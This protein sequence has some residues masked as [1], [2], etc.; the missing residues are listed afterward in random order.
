MSRA[1][2]RSSRALAERRVRTPWVAFPDV[3]SGA[4]DVLRRLEGAI[5]R[6]SGFAP[7]CALGDSAASESSVAFK[8]WKKLMPYDAALLPFRFAID[9]GESVR[10][11][12]ARGRTCGIKSWE[13]AAGTFSARLSRYTC[14]ATNRSKDSRCS[15]MHDAG[16]ALPTLVSSVSFVPRYAHHSISVS[17]GEEHIHKRLSEEPIA[18][19][20]TTMTPRRGSHHGHERQVRAHRVLKEESSGQLTISPRH[21][22]GASDRSYS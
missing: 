22:V 7:G 19:R 8:Q 6:T 10:Q 11:V 14:R 2:G 20:D 5:A 18:L 17:V 1:S 12:P 9:V 4:T 16:S 21:R 3:G 15:H 13:D